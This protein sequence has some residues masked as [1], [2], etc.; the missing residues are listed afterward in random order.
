[1]K[2]ENMDTRWSR[3]ESKHLNSTKLHHRSEA[4]TD[5]CKS[6]LKNKQFIRE[7]HMKYLLGDKN[8]D[9]HLDPNLV[10]DLRH[11]KVIVCGCFFFAD[12]CRIFIFLH[13]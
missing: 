1:M 4:T 11:K 10:M 13:I 2:I 8:N 9:W 7:H 3:I 5:I 6:L 12:F